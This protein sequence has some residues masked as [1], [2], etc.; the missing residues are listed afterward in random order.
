MYNMLKP[1]HSLKVCVSQKKASA[2]LCLLECKVTYFSSKENK[3][4][5][6]FYF[7]IIFN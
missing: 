7:L 6:F 4:I 3:N 1:S 2:R 5:G